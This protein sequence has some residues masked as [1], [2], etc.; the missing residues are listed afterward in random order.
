MNESF[1]A[2]KYTDM[3][4]NQGWFI[5]EKKF[6]EAK[7]QATL[8]R[9]VRRAKE[10]NQDRGSM[11]DWILVTLA[12][13]TG[14]RVSELAAL[15]CG[16]LYS[17]GQRPGVLVQNGK[18]GKA[19]FVRINRYCCKAIRQFL[20]WKDFSGEPT[21]S[22]SPVFKSP[23]RDAPLTV[24]A[25]QKRFTKLLNAVQIE[26]KSI[27]S[28][29]HTFATELLRC[30]NG[31]LRLVQKQLGHSNI[32]TTTVYADLLDTTLQAALEQ[33]YTSVNRKASSPALEIVKDG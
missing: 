21:E 18:G 23:Y 1:G 26:G 2:G 13:Q 24:R 8:E 5:D 12:F 25:L 20:K 7:E 10:R 4:E 11:I 30:G 33:L 31:N 14:L 27:H 28:C 32:Q 6:F 15:R 19:R 16:D 29:R 17:D 9:Y 22:V 3:I